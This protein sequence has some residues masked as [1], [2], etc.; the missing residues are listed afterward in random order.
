MQTEIKL[1]VIV[2]SYNREQY[3]INALQSLKDQTMNKSRYEVIVVDNNS[4][5]NTSVLVKEFIEKHKEELKITLV[6]EINQGLTFARN[7]GVKE[8][9]GGY[10]TFIDDDAV[11]VPTFLEEIYNCF[12]SKKQVK[13]I[14]GRVIPI[15]PE[16]DEPKWLSHY[17]D[18][19]VSKLDLGNKEKEF[20]KK[21]PV[22]CNMSFRKEI[23][24]ELGGFNE[25]I[26]LRSD[27]KDL[28]ERMGQRGCI[29]Y[30]PQAEVQHV[31][32]AKRVSKQGVIHVSK[33]TGEGEYFRNK[34]SLL[35]LVSIFIQYVLKLMAALVLAFLFVLRGRG[36]KAKYIIIVRWFILLGFVFN[37]ALL[38]DKT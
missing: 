4:R 23:L 11:A 19:I 9:K 10:V 22:G 30:L 6:S 26:L 7:R 3:I 8:S 18:G 24:E 20:N 15:Y 12:E 34:K 5:D 33:I 2:C 1:S 14:G 31:M 25:E 37:K 16:S 27:E 35:R 17:I 28:F 13:V 32:S 36:A 38:N 21:F 29:W